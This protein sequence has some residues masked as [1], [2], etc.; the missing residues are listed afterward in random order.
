[1][2]NIKSL[3]VYCMSK[4]PWPI[5]YCKLLYKMGQ[6]FLDRQYYVGVEETEGSVT[7]NPPSLFQVTS[8][9]WYNY[10][11]DHKLEVN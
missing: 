4:K 11:S 8:A 10:T 5:L 6:D 7:V 9:P 3:S 2:F 1:M